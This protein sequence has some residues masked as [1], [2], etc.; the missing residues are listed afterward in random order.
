MEFTKNL[1]LSLDLEKLKS[2]LIA[3]VNNEWNKK[4]EKLGEII[5]DLRNQV[6]KITEER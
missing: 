1:R 5:F 3:N 4:V 6:K 2:K